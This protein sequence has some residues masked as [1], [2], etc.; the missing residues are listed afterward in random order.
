MLRAGLIQVQEMKVNFETEMATVQATP[1]SLPFHLPLPVLYYSFV[2]PL[3]PHSPG[4]LPPAPRPRR[5]RAHA[6]WR[7]QPP[8][9][10]A[11]RRPC[12]DA[13][14]A[15]GGSGCWRRSS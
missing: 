14:G 15:R 7:L 5:Q 4:A 1:P 3:P 13:A 11:P 10:R 12:A 8:R 2:P 6:A 9:V